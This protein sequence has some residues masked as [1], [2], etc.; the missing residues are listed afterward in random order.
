MSLA[1]FRCPDGCRE[2]HCDPPACRIATGVQA[3]TTEAKPRVRRD[4]RE[5]KKRKEAV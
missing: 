2:P 4:R 1:V 5:P 3:P